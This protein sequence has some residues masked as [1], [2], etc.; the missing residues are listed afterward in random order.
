VEEPQ[1]EVLVVEFK[2]S[3]KIGKQVQIQLLA[4]GLML[5]EQSQIP[6]RRGFVYLI[7][8]RRTEEI[9]FSKGLRQ[10]LLA[11]LEEM[12][13]AVRS[14]QMPPPTENRAK[15]LACEFRRFCNDVL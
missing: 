10:E 8:K 9:V 6:A 13:T 11:T 12:H 15:C 7:P 3:V 1:P 5:E 4:Y 14:E 2:N